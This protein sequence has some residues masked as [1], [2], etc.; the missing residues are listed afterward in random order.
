MYPVLNF[1]FSCGFK[2]LTA[3]HAKNLGDKIKQGTIAFT[4]PLEAPVSDSRELKFKKW[5]MDE[6]GFS[7]ILDAESMWTSSLNTR[8][9]YHFFPLTVLHEVFTHGW[10][11]LRP[12][13]CTR[14][15]FHNCHNRDDE[16]STGAKKPS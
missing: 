10:C 8:T 16:R 14:T 3:K 2:A 13:R 12:V 5:P 9:F 7:S 15:S 1:F 6:N 4:D 11:S